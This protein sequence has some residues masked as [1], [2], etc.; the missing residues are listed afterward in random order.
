MALVEPSASAGPVLETN[1]LQAA[2]RHRKPG[3]ARELG[4]FDPLVNA[5]S[6][7]L[8]GLFEHDSDAR[9]IVAQRRVRLARLDRNMHGKC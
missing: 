2:G 1:F 9:P 3:V 7:S 6:S 5:S 8:C 4:R